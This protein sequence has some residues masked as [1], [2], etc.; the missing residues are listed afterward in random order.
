MWDFDKLGHLALFF[1]LAFVW[2]QAFSA[3]ST[4]MVILFLVCGFAF[5]PLT[6]LYQSILPFGRQMDML[7]SV[8]DAFGFGLGTF[9]WIVWEKYRPGRKEQL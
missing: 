8:A 9:A 3:H 7:D 5:A 1:V 2:M 4:R 6:E